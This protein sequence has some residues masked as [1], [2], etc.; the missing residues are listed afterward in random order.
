M[1]DEQQK[2]EEEQQLAVAIEEGTLQE[3][4][5]SSECSEQLAILITVYISLDSALG[6]D[7]P[8]TLAALNNLTT[9][10]SA[11]IKP[12]KEKKPPKE[13]AFNEIKE[14]RKALSADIIQDEDSAII[15]DMHTA[16]A[17]LEADSR[18]S[19]ELH[20]AIVTYNTIHSTP[21]LPDEVV[22]YAFD[23]LHAFGGK[24]KASGGDRKPMQFQPEYEIE[25]VGDETRY[26]TL[27]AALRA[28]GFT[29]TTMDADGKV[30]WA[31]A[32][33]RVM[34][35]IKKNKSGVYTLPSTGVEYTFVQHFLDAE[36]ADIDEDEDETEDQE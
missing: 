34:N 22:N 30:I 35:Q 3:F 26:P 19:P 4:K 24:R 21:D 29:Q 36:E 9:F 10:E 28:A 17:A 7:A 6:P 1:A 2:T 27:S 23:T 32:W 12:V 5:E 20:A 8:A 11:K 13:K 14:L 33:S 31:H 16:L 15:S 25:V 18:I